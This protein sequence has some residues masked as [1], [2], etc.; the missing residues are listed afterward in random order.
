M[1]AVKTLRA[2]TLAFEGAKASKL[3]PKQRAVGSSRH[4]IHKHLPQQ[5]LS[6]GPDGAPA[7]LGR[8]YAIATGGGIVAAGGVDKALYVHCIGRCQNTSCLSESPCDSR[9]QHVVM[10]PH[11]GNIFA[12][13][14]CHDC[15]SGDTYIA[16]GGEDKRLTVYHAGKSFAS[17]RRPLTVLDHEFTCKESVLSASLRWRANPHTKTKALLLAAGS[18]DCHVRIFD[19]L[20][21]VLIYS[22][23]LPDIIISVAL[24]PTRD[25]LAIAAK[26]SRV[27]L[28]GMDDVFDEHIE[29]L[30]SECTRFAAFQTNFLSRRQAENPEAFKEKVAVRNKRIWEQVRT[31]IRTAA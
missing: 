18:L 8:V 4:V 30:E 27:L 7:H 25:L 15:S 2:T 10:Q 31:C 17:G 16:A 28:L 6:T 1:R 24:H 23:E 13:A 20:D 29:V 22:V 14:L 11:E 12:V 26:P 9:R 21:G 19:V 3:K 5:R